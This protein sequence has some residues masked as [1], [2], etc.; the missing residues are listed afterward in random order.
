MKPSL[1]WQG[2]RDLRPR[3]GQGSHPRRAAVLRCLATSSLPI[4]STWNLCAEPGCEFSHEVTIPT[5]VVSVGT[6]NVNMGVG[7]KS[8]AMGMMGEACRTVLGMN[9]SI[10][11]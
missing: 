3:D 7:R 4:G 10:F 11:T 9:D 1:N 2:Y 6:H 8:R 5:V